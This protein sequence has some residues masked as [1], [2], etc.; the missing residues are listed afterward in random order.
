MRPV[1]LQRPQAPDQERTGEWA[2]VPF[3]NRISSPRISSFIRVLLL[4]SL[5]KFSFTSDV[6]KE[7]TFLVLPMIIEAV[8]SYND[9]SFVDQ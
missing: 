3:E 8:G 9:R 6:L 1:R 2:S 7:F 4:I 5:L